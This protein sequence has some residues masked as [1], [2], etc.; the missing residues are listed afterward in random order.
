MIKT[1]K[2][3]S[4]FITDNRQV[5]FGTDINA[6]EDGGIASPLSVYPSGIIWN[7]TYPYVLI[8][9]SSTGVR[10]GIPSTANATFIL[11]SEA[12]R[13]ATGTFSKAILPEYTS[14]QFVA[15]STGTL[16]IPVGTPISTFSN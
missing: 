11:P 1:T 14:Q 12:F 5:W 4:F 10:A 8:P 15:N 16:Y 3:N 6:W 13:T 9:T 2:T 7:G